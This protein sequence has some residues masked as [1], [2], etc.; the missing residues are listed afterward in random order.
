MVWKQTASESKDPYIS[1]IYEDSFILG[2][3]NRS[4]A[5]QAE[6]ALNVTYFGFTG[7]RSRISS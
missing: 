3:P 2:Y 6:T 5:K 1:M 4:I 7:N